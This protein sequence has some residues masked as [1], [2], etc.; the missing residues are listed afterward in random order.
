MVNVITVVSSGFY[1][2]DGKLHGWTFGQML[3]RLVPS[4]FSILLS[5]LSD[6]LLHIPIPF[7]K[8][9]LQGSLCELMPLSCRLDPA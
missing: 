5:F 6:F 8:T 7:V 4:G 2:S 3:E 1:A 9:C